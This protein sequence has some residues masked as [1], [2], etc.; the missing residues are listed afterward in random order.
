[1]INFAFFGTSR[2]SVLVL[3]ELEKTGLKPILIVTTPDKP[4]GRG[5][6]M[7]S[8]PVKEWAQKRGIEVLS[9]ETL[10]ASLAETLSK[11][12]SQNDIDV[13]V[14]ISYGKIIPKS[15]IDLPLHKT[16]NVHASLLPKYRGASPLQSAMLDDAKQTGISII[17]LDEKMDHGPI[18]AQKEVTVNE[19]PT[20]EDFEA[21]MA[22]GGGQ[23]LAQALLEW[24][25]GK[26]KERE[27]DHSLATFAKKITKE[28]GLIDASDLNP[29]APAN[30]AYAAFR[31]IQAFHQW[32]T[33]YFFVNKN[34][35]KKRAIEIPSK[36]QTTKIG[37]PSNDVAKKNA[38]LNGV[39]VK[40]TKASFKDGKLTIER[41]VPEGSR[42]MDY[43]DYLKGLK[44]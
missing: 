43:G 16:L 17:R 9:P 39:R 36:G 2:F 12:A 24:V 31:K 15:I 35:D 44:I 37:K 22:H 30:K 32:P 8:T 27:Q 34:T 6:V 1:M 26:I 40:I 19:W 20:Y 28:D 3:D 33:A 13:F 21:L 25:A 29:D 41:V 4:R 18:V 42:E 11:N 14:V 7:Q 5:L 38:P 23:L 10:D